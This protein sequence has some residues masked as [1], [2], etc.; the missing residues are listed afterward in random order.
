VQ[1][2]VAPELD[3][4]LL[5]GEDLE[6]VAREESEERE[7]ESERKKVEGRRQRRERKGERK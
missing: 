6:R 4:V 3:R 2:T 5:G 7:K 1:G